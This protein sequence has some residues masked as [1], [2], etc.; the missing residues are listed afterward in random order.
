MLCALCAVMHLQQHATSSGHGWRSTADRPRAAPAVGRKNA[1]DWRA[2]PTA[3]RL[4]LIELNSAN[5]D[6]VT[7]V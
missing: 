6:H 5:D 2:P 7:E 3:A 4:D 1:S